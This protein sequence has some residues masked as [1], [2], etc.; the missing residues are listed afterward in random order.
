MVGLFGFIFPPLQRRPDLVKFYLCGVFPTGKV[1]LAIYIKLMVPN[2]AKRPHC[3]KK[4]R[5]Q[6][7]PIPVLLLGKSHGRRSLVGCSPWGRWESAQL[8]SFT[9]TFHFH[10]LEKE[11]A[12]HSSVLA[13]RIPGTGEPCE[14]PSMGSHG[15]GYDWSDLAAAA[16]ALRSLNDQIR[17]LQKSSKLPGEKYCA[18]F[19]FLSLSPHTALGTKYMLSA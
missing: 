15:V 6:W 19:I 8:S 11:M 9:F 5:R 16:A 4:G 18:I 7:Q 2:F 12:T 17:V 14:L 3:S 1:I 10:A 13:W